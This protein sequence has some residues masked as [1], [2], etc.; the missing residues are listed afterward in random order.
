MN[1]GTYRESKNPSCTPKKRRAWEAEPLKNLRGGAGGCRPPARGSGG[2]EAPQNCRGS[3]GRQ[4]PSKN[5]FMDPEPGPNSW[6]FT[7]IR[8]SD[9]WKY[10][11]P[12]FVS[13][14]MV[15]LSQIYRESIVNPWWMYRGHVPDASSW[16]IKFMKN[17]EFGLKWVHMARYGLIQPPKWSY[18]RCVSFLL[19]RNP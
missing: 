9:S 4:P 11:S 7:H 14:I 18:G 6:F 15:Y 12:I 8:R 3:G 19:S 13:L 5:N 2:L 16:R 17:M 1:P 10:F